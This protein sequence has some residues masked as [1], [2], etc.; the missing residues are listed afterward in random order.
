MWG[1]IS[2]FFCCNFVNPIV[3]WI[4][5]KQTYLL[6]YI[7]KMFGSKRGEKINYAHGYYKLNRQM[8]VEL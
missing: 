8:D 2:Y 4:H 5:K 7:K 3:V 1:D 6:I